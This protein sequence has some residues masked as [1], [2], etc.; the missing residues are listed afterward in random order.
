MAKTK[1]TKASSVA[2]QAKNIG[3]LYSNKGRYFF[4]EDRTQLDLPGLI[5]VQLD[6]YKDFLDKRLSQ[7]FEEVF[8]IDDFS[9][10]RI[11]IFY[12]SC[13]LEEPKFSPFDCKRKNLNYEA[14]LKARFEMLNKETGEI[15]E[16]D[17]YLGGIPLMTDM[18]SFIVNGIERIIVNQI[19]RSTGMFFSPD[20]RTPG[21]YAMKVIPQR[22]SWFEIEIEKK[23]VINVK[24]DKK[25]KI[26]V[27]VLLRAWGF[28]TNADIIDAFKGEDEWISKY[29]APTIE[30]DKTTNQMEALYAIYKLLRPG[31]LGTDERVEQLFQT[32]FY[33]PKK[34]ELGKVA[35]MKINRKFNPHFPEHTKAVDT[36]QSNQ[37][38]IAGDFL[39]GLKYLLSLIDGREGFMAD[40]I[41]HLENRRVRSV[42]E[43]VYD[44]VK[45]GLARMEKIAKDRM[46]VITEL[47]D[48]TP[49]TFINPRPMVAVMREFFGTNQLSQF[50][51][52]SNPLSELA[53][54]RRVTAMGV[55][56]LTRERASF[57]VRDVHPT[58]YGRI[59][60]IATPEG[61][62]IGLVLH[63]ASYARVDEYGFITTPFRKVLHTVKNDGKSAV[64][65]IALEDIVDE[66]GS[67]I[68]PEKTLITPALAKKIKENVK[69]DEIEVRGYLA[70]EHEY[71]DAYKERKLVI[72][73]AN[74]P[75][76]EYGNFKETRLPA[77]RKSEATVAY[78]REVTHIDVSPKQLMSETTTLIPFLEHDDATRAEMGTN[79]MRQA[80]PLVKADAPVVGT[81]M[82]R[83]IGEESGYVVKAEDDGEVIG[84]DAK[85]ISVLYKNGK[86]MTYPLR[87]FERSNHDHIIHQWA[88]VYPGDKF[89]KNQILADGQSIDNGE[90]AVGRN[91]KVAYMPWNGYNYEDA[92]IISEKL[93]QDD[94]FTSVHIH[95]YT[96]DVRETK[97]GP[98][99]TTNDIP[100]VSQ[101]KLSELDADGIVRIGAYVTA[102]DILVGKV[103][104]KGEVELSPEEK[105]LRAIF[106]DKSKDVKDS[107]LI[108]PSGSGGKVIDVHVLR[109]EDG[110][111]L[112]TGVF[113]Q[114][115]VYIAQTRK[116][117]VGDKMAGRHGNKGIVSKIVPVED[118][119]FDENG[120]PVDIL[121]NPLGVLS[122]MNIGQ[123]LETH[124]GGAAAKLGIKVASPILNG[125]STEQISELMKKAGIPEDGKV[126]L[127]DG[128]TGEPFKEKTMVGIKYMLKLHHLVEEKIHARNVGPYSMVTQQPL[129]GKAQKGGQRLGEMEVWALEGYGAANILQEMLTVKSDDINGRTQLY[130]AIVKG[131][132]I[133]RPNVPESFNVL[134]RELQALNLNIDLLSKE[135][136]AELEA[137]MHARYEEL[138]KLSGQ[139]DIDTGVP[140]KEKI[141]DTPVTTAIIDD[142]EN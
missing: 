68:V 29:I 7:A 75:T 39:Y 61:P 36:D 40:D 49:G 12:K 106:G 92:I 124:L 69:D 26:P 24:I 54:K 66:K 35:R 50:M 46:T 3:E 115:K 96:M 130:E 113:Q 17:V 41:D 140:L 71:F 112:P 108:L 30:K 133:R 72:A 78:V 142:E 2:P 114:V 94:Y 56:G 1:E 6:S 5:E 80:V 18:G 99:Q 22:G 110:D 15:K 90:L 95:E 128:R 82:E 122:R 120:E 119:P 27:S 85:H 134:L 98:E 38:L 73:E 79:M 43:L 62:N 20:P 132:R 101:A 105:L 33:D 55:G 91:L 37:F 60:P 83:I 51:D 28:E 76:D 42:G 10:E 67:V 131:K 48:A 104:P 14:P 88:R 123:V 121:L 64:N 63:F 87:T 89:E 84:V 111:N 97:L 137:M 57:E 13:E 139:Y 77:R 9:E 21:M 65:R 126:Q 127:Y 19:I 11:S 117:E 53:H 102:G 32:T 103:T 136:V 109:R 59:C 31:D 107:S 86:K 58:Q 125:L 4:T 138:E 129:G 16:Q 52:Q 70:D 8:P 25:R 135:E 100:N 93:M 74:T 81:G 23:G 47:D 44:K 118:M 45:V 141:D 34:F 116:I